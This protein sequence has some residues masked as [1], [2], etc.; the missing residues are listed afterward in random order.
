M[1]SVLRH[2]FRGLISRSRPLSIPRM[3]SLVPSSIP[4]RIISLEGAARSTS[5]RAV[6]LRAAVSIRGRSSVPVIGIV[7]AWVV[8]REVPTLTELIGGVVML[9]GLAIAV[10]VVRRRDPFVVIPPDAT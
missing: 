8:V 2:R 1:N 6:V 9:A 7:A 3:T 10:V 4:L 5:C